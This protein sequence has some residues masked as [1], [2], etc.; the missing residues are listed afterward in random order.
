MIPHY[1][2]RKTAKLIVDVFGQ[3]IYI[4]AVVSIYGNN[5]Y[6]FDSQLQLINTLLSIDLNSNPAIVSHTIDAQTKQKTTQKRHI[7]IFSNL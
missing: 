5:P 3:F 6:H 1:T 4:T 7:N 2:S